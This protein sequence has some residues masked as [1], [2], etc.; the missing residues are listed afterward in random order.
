MSEYNRLPLDEISG[1]AITDEMGG[2]EKYLTT[3]PMLKSY[4][5]G[6]N[7]KI[8]KRVM[9]DKEKQ[10][11]LLQ[12]ALENKLGKDNKEEV[13]KFLQD[14]AIKDINKL[15]KNPMKMS[16]IMNDIIFN[17]GEQKV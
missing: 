7:K 14:E 13:I 4:F 3:H 11:K 9:Q 10:L 2:I 8:R 6:T 16:T 15:P 17:T 5:D 1:K 12:F